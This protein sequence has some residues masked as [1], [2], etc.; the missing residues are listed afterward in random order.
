MEQI[1]NDP[2]LINLN[3]ILNDM[4]PP[5]KPYLLSLL[6]LLKQHH[7]LGIKYPN[8]RVY[9]GYSLLNH[10]TLSLIYM[11]ILFQYNAVF[12]Y[13]F[14]VQFEGIYFDTFSSVLS[15]QNSFIYVTLCFYVVLKFFYF[16][17][18]QYCN[19]NGSCI[20]I[21]A[22]S[23]ILIMPNLKHGWFHCLLNMFFTS[24]FYILMFLLQKSFTFLVIISRNFIIL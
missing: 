5:A 4:L 2:R 1:G 3:V 22:L 12:H 19:F 21:L 7:Q 17:E 16:C 23:T 11:Y 8:V 24:F 18:V 14:I 20:R 13:G 9:G 10:Y 15:A 6:R